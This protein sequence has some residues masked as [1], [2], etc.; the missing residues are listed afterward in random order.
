MNAD[1]LTAFRSGAA[2]IRQALQG[3]KRWLSL[4]A[5]AL[6][7]LG[8]VLEIPMQDL[9]RQFALDQEWGKD[10]TVIALGIAA[11]ATFRFFQSLGHN[12]QTEE[13][14]KLIEDRITSVERRMR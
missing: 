11:A 5:Y 7:A 14:F 10:S 12:R 4:A 9:A 1:A 8:A 2:I 3:K 13:H 6:L